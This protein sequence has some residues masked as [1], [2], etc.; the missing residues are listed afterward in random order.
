MSSKRGLRRKACTGKTRFP[1]HEAALASL[2]HLK[3]KRQ[4]TDF[5]TPYHCRFC[6]G[7]HFGHPP[8]GIRKSLS[9]KKKNNPKPAL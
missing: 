5:L 4:I 7:F 6:G 3:R 2:C 9:D 8:R 1:T